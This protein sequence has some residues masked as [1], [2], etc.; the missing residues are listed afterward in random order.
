MIPCQM[1]VGQ[2]RGDPDEIQCWKKGAHTSA[3]GAR[4]ADDFTSSEVAG[5]AGRGGD[6]GRN[7]CG[8]KVRQAVP[9]AAAVGRGLSYF[10]GEGC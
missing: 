3:G 1:T 7:F 4:A 5:E 8:S 10:G 2:L 6:G 9:A